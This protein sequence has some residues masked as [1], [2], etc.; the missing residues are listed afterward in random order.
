MGKSDSNPETINLRQV[1]DAADRASTQ[2]S[3]WPTWKRELSKPQSKQQT[4]PLSS[5]KDQQKS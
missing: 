5:T 1:L 3:T 4:V 2:V